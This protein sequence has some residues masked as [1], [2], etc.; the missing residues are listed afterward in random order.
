MPR[1]P[2]ITGLPFRLTMTDDD[3]VGWDDWPDGVV[4]QAGFHRG[5]ASAPDFA[6]VA[7]DGGADLD[8]IGAWHCA[9][10]PQ[11]PTVTFI[12]ETV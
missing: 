12:A 7:L 11:P 8:R 9:Y 5:W 1:A 2:S 4:A 10:S 6:F 3:V